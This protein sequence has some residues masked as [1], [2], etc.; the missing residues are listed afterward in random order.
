MSTFTNHWHANPPKFV[1]Y[2]V[3]LL[4]NCQ[5]CCGQLVKILIS[6]EPN[7]IFG[8]NF[9]INLFLY[10][11][12]TLVCKTVA[13]I[14]RSSFCWSRI[15]SENTHNSL[16]RQS[17]FFIKFCTP[18]HLSIIEIRLCHVTFVASGFTYFARDPKYLCFQ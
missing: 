13:R 5:A 14:F 16:E 3:G 15:I 11:P 2:Y 18:I 6:L 7:R 10:C 1:I 4:C 8:S 12:A 9:H 17:I